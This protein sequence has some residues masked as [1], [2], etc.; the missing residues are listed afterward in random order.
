MPIAP[1][2]PR[3]G[4]RHRQAGRAAALIPVRDRG[5]R[6]RLLIE[7]L[8]ARR[9]EGSERRAVHHGAVAGRDLGPPLGHVALGR[10]R[11]AVPDAAQHPP[12]EVPDIGWIGGQPVEMPPKHIRCVQSSALR[13]RSRQVPRHRSVVCPVPGLE[14]H[15][16]S[17]ERWQRIRYVLA[18]AELERRPE[19]V[20]QR[21]P[22]DAS[23]HPFPQ[24]IHGGASL[25][26]GRSGQT[27]LV[28]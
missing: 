5:Q 4:E 11:D 17:L 10:I 9:S 18:P 2:E 28:A 22:Q 27:P 20:P 1:T 14:S 23:D 7:Q 13:Q 21:Q 15:P 16:T 3:D 12:R 19:R 6:G 24:V 26:A 25:P 8:R